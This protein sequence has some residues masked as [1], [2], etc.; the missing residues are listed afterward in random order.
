MTDRN[1]R[2]QFVVGNPG[3]PG[4]PHVASLAKNRAALL[5]AVTEDDLREILRA[6]IDAAIDGDVA[7]AKLVLERVCGRSEQSSTSG[8]SVAVQ[9]ILATHTGGG[10]HG[11]GRELALKIAQRIRAERAQQELQALEDVNSQD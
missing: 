1:E 10:T 3:G 6:M 7:A 9:N 8:P 11:R 2:G 4:N 5:A